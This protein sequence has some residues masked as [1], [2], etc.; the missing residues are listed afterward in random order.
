MY[1]AACF[2]IVKMQNVTKTNFNPIAFA[3]VDSCYK[4]IKWHMVISR[5]M[6]A[7]GY[8]CD[9]FYKVS[10]QISPEIIKIILLS[11]E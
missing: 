9:S 11:L 5:S 4:P 3:K 8:K 1:L 10:I 2:S 6:I 7:R